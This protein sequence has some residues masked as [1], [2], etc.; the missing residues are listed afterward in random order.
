M[1]AHSAGVDTTGVALAQL[2]SIHAG[3]VATRRL[4]SSSLKNAA[5]YSVVVA[6]GSNQTITGVFWKFSNLT[7][8]SASGSS[9]S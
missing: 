3:T 6:F 9:S 2:V 1:S 4:V 8:G 5:V 7:G